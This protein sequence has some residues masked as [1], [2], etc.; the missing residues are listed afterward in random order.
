[1]RKPS[2]YVP[3]AMAKLRGGSLSGCSEVLRHGGRTATVTR[4]GKAKR[5]GDEVTVAGWTPCSPSGFPS[6]WPARR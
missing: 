4:I 3:A 2:E 5:G 6:Q 1:M